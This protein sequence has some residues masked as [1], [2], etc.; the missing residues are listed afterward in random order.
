MDSVE[1]SASVEAGAVDY[2]EP[3]AG[4]EDGAVLLGAVFPEQPAASTIISVTTRT[5]ILLRTSITSCSFTRLVL[6]LIPAI[7]P[8]RTVCSPI[9][10]R[11]RATQCERAATGW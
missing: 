8:L 10:I 1:P 2:V 3:C 7:F 11:L 9:K 5:M 6:S 4:V